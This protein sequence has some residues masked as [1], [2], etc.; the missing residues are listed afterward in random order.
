MTLPEGYYNEGLGNNRFDK[1]FVE[2]DE[3]ARLDEGIDIENWLLI[4][5]PKI[6]EKYKKQQRESHNIILE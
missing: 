6:L 1:M 3:F 2:D 5:H 4:H